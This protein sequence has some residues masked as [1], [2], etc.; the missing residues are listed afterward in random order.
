MRARIM[1]PAGTRFG[2]LI[3]QGRF[4]TQGRHVTVWECLCV[5]GRTRM[6]SSHHLRTG[7]TTCCAT[8]GCRPNT[9]RGQYSTP[10]YRA[11]RHMKERCLN[12]KICNFASYGGR[13]IIVCPEWE[14]SFETF[15]A[16][17]GQ[18]PTA[19]HSIERINNNGPYAPWNC[20]WATGAEQSR[21]T[22]RTRNISFRGHTKCLADW[23][24]TLGVSRHTL[25]YRL[26]H[27]SVE[28]SLTAPYHGRALKL[29]A[30]VAAATSKN[31]N[32]NNAKND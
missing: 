8:K 18:R 5:C 28:R 20:K 31:Q 15:L 25:A 21:N 14:D 6:V 29:P 2:N 32:Q 27:W 9:T 11:W 16:D 3:C 24:D 22:R 26:D 10:E 19:N 13:G 12:P 30:P 1:I 17:M 23:A 7:H 4:R